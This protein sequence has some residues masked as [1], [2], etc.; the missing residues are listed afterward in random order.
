MKAKDCIV[1]ERE[2]EEGQVKVRILSLAEV[3]YVQGH[4]LRVQLYSLYLDGVPAVW[5]VKSTERW[6]G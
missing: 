4:V 6:S 5:G 2:T 3:V 1:L